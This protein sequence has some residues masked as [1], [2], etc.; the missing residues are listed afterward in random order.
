MY[1][2]SVLVGISVLATTCC[3]AADNSKG[4]DSILEKHRSA[5]TKA[6]QVRNNTVQRSRDDSINL[7][8]KAANDAYAKKDRIAETKAWTTILQ[9]DRG[10]LRARQYFKDLG[11]LDTVLASLPKSDDLGGP[12]DR[13]VGK[14]RTYADGH[15]TGG[16]ASWNYIISPDLT[17]ANMSGDIVRWK[18]KLEPIPDTNELSFYESNCYMRCMLVGDRLIVEQW[19]GLPNKPQTIP[20]SKPQFIQYGFR[21]AP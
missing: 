4:V 16:N 3:V 15:T 6:D 20:A 10:H 8:A 19:C 11:T 17:I 5:T 2:A 7:L 1:R 21:E 14:W 9:L 18:V 13:Y 12:I